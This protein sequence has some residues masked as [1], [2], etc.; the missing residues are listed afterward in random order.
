MKKIECRFLEGEKKSHCRPHR[1]PSSL[2]CECM[3]GYDKARYI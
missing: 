3:Q 1:H 2:R